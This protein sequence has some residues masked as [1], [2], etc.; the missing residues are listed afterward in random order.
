MSIVIFLPLLLIFVI[1][2]VIVIKYLKK[3]PK[4]REIIKSKKIIILLVSIVVVGIIGCIVYIN[5]SNLSS[6][7]KKMKNYLE[8]IGY[9]CNGIYKY[10]EGYLDEEGK[11]FYCTMTARNGVYKEVLIN[12]KNRNAY[13]ID[14]TETV[15][16][17]YT[18][19]IQGQD[20]AAKKQQQI[21]YKDE[22][23]NKTFHFRPRG[24]SFYIGEQVNCD[25]ESKK[26]MD[27]C[28][29]DAT[30]V[31]NALREF[32]SYFSGAGLKLK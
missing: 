28:L 9:D 6:Y 16:G 17:A 10:E 1:L 22:I 11:Y 32:E 21:I 26:Y 14:Y 20:Y 19:T 8:S 4:T 5:E 7:S 29:D 27:A 24:N 30:D 15:N 25:N 2:I 12:K 3:N 13:G 23:E 31:N 18:F